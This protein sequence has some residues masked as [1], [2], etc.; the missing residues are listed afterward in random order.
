MKEQKDG[1]AVTFEGEDVEKKEQTFD[2]VLVSSAAGPTREP[3]LEK[4]SV[5]L[6]ERGFI[7]VDERGA[8]TSRTIYAIG[9]VAGEPMLAHKAS[10]EGGRRRGHRR[11]ARS[12]S[13]RSRSRPSCS[14]TRRSPGAA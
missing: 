2:R 6:D 9:D 12:R 10:H 11:R 8:R 5:Q 4:T 13:S 3:G 1:I 14:P 7:Q